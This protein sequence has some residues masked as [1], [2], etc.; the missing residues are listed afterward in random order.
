MTDTH[1]YYGLDALRGGM[2]MLGI[3]LHSCMFYLAAPPPT[4]AVMADRNTSYVLD[5]L[6]AFIH[7]FRMPVF[8]L[9]S[10]FFTA[11]L[12]EK[13]GLAGAYK[14]RAARVLAPL[15]VAVAT[16]LPITLIIMLDALIGARFGV[17]DWWPDRAYLKPLAQEMIAKGASTEPS[18]LHLWF[19]YYLLFFYLLIPLCRALV[20]HSL[21]YEQGIKGFLVS[22]GAPVLFALCT[23]AALWPFRGGEPY[24]G[25]IYL[26]PHVPSLIYY[27]SF[28]VLGY[29]MH[30]YR[31]LLQVFAH[32]LRGSALLAL[33]LFPL[34]FYA[35]HLEYAAPSPGIHLAAVLLHA[36]GTWALI[37]LVMG[38]ALRFLD[39]ASPWILYTSQA[40]YWVFLVH[41]IPVALASWCLLQF[42]LPAELKFLLVLGFSTVA[43]FASYHYLARTTWIS[44]FLNG[45]RFGS[46]WPWREAGPAGGDVVAAPK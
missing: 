28:F 27:G 46:A 35:S 16:I 18:I 8:F 14:N 37:Y 21:A 10:G 11:L 42:D 1:R 45:R 15:L 31:D 22:P 29:V 9:L 17:N 23:A 26:K 36:M 13:R 33:V 43:C 4:M 7:S 3:V 25:F 2:M 39:F 30:H 32:S 5:V 19:L 24:E 44:M 41:M 40:S 34:S 6:I 20:R 38:C 12:V